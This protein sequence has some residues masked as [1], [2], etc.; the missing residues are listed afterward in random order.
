MPSP[1]PAHRPPAPSARHYLWQ[2]VFWVAVYLG[3][4]LAPL[5]VLLL[6]PTPGGAGFWYD[7]SLALGF[8]GTAMIGVQFVLTARFK[9]ATAPYGID[10]IYYFHR[11]AAIVGFVLILAHPIVLFI[12]NPAFLYLLNP[13]EAPGHM[14]A[15]LVS[16][17]AMFV[18]VVTSLFRKQ[19]GI[20]YDR[21]RLG[22]GLLAVAALG[23]ALCHIAGVRY[24]VAE[25]LQGGLWITLTA[26]WVLLLAYIRVL[27]PIMLLRRPFRVTE[28]RS[29]RGD[30]WTL[31][32]EPE[33]HRGF[34]FEP[35][36][37]IWLTLRHSPFALREHPFS[38]SS[39]PGDTPTL[40]VT[41]KELGDFTR[42]IKDIEVG[43]AAY[44][45]GPYGA[46]SIDRYPD[47]PGYVFIAGGIGVA[48]MM[49][50][51]RALAE[52]GDRRPV[53]LVC[54]HSTWDRVV[55]R[56]QLREL[57]SRLN[58]EVVHVLEEPPAVWTGEVGYVTSAVLDRH[59]PESRATLEYF[60]CGPEAM[61]DLVERG[62]YELG[63]PLSRSHTEL[64]DLV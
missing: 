53:V 2:G 37:F 15:G 44:V 36:Q 17:V 8:A 4:V 7:F 60:I 25:P 52:R 28:V 11:Y 35:G 18:V 20:D 9:R 39:A 46:F 1:T 3:L 23:L 27:R 14:T 54:A 16:L 63:V 30:S 22:H 64:F 29:E 51:L 42:T 59:L 55:F 19:L 12:D 6:G 58:L 56:E 41:I 34:G 49:S 21:W 5:L 62:L 50:M 45:D 47:A 38:L 10:I 13:L 40:E 48:P 32:L 26:S 33:G 31:R 24:Y 61:I 43:E 57:E